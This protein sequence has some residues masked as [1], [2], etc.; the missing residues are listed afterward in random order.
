ADLFLKR[1]RLDE[2]RTQYEWRLTQAPDDAYALLGLARIALQQGSRREAAGQLESIVRRSP[3]FSAAHNLLANVYERM[4]E[5]ARAEQERKLGEATGRFV[6][7]S[8]P[9]FHQVYAWCFNP[10]LV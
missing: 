8:D 4:G 2:A 9:R 3:G 7:A 1:G 6:E 5:H 10:Y